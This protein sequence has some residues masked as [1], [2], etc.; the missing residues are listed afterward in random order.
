MAKSFR[1]WYYSGG[2]DRLAAQRKLRYQLD[3]TY[4]EA[5][6]ARAAEYR[7]R[8]RPAQNHSGITL[9]DAAELLEISSWTLHSWR[10][11]HYYPE[12]LKISGKPVF[13]QNQVQ[14]LR[15][16]RDFFRKYPKR[17]SAGH[18]DELQNI[19]QVVHHNWDIEGA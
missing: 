7:K 1:E 16:I 12:P 9:K 4:R 13:L 11:H 8:V 18:R 14:L 17:S 15:L 3:P 6:K 19:V 5:V 2:K 10:S